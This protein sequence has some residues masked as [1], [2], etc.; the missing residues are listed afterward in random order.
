VT[1]LDSFGVSSSMSQFLGIDRTSPSLSGGDFLSASYTATPV[2]GGSNG[3]FSGVSS[4]RVKC[5]IY[6]NGVQQPDDIINVTP[7]TSGNWCFTPPLWN[8]VQTLS[9]MC[10][11]NVE[12]KAG[13]SAIYGYP[14][15]IPSVPWIAKMQK[16]TQ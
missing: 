7:D 5:L 12:N 1:A 4:L 9:Y 14:F 6:S 2:C 11:L 8:G 16:I 13:W 15:V 3:S 10:V